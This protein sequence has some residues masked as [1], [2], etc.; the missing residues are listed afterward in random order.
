MRIRQFWPLPI[1]ILGTLLSLFGG[2]FLRCNCLDTASCDCLSS[3]DYALNIGGLVLT[4]VF[5][6]VF[7]FLSTQFQEAEQVMKDAA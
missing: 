3:P 5:T 1:I 2:F 7:V 4:I 6:H